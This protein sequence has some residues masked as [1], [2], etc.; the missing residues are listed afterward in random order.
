MQGGGLEPAAGLAAGSKGV[1]SLQPCS[2][3]APSCGLLF[4]C[5]QHFIKASDATTEQSPAPSQHRSRH[6]WP[7]G[8]GS[9]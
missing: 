6:R 2:S 9:I 1:S 7:K 4:S 3:T 5:T 8:K